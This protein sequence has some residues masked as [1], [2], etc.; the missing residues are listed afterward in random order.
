MQ[1]GEEGRGGG[2]E[3]GRRS[4]VKMLTVRL[5]QSRRNRERGRRRVGVLVESSR[6]HSVTSKQRRIRRPFHRGKA[7]LRA[8]APPRGH[9]TRPWTPPRDPP[10]HSHRLRP[11]L[12]WKRR[13]PT[14]WM[15]ATT[16]SRGEGRPPLRIRDQDIEISRK[17]DSVLSS[18]DRRVWLLSRSFPFRPPIHP[19]PFADVP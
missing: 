16:E 8:A 7:V 17:P 18:S 14:I 3:A 4:R 15:P 6:V 9:D 10:S 13:I 19:C 11:T 1:E 12:S 5:I 2:R